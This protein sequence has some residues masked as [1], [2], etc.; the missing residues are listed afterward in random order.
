VRNFRSYVDR[1][2][3]FKFYLNTTLRSPMPRLRGEAMMTGVI[4]VCLRNH[5]VDL[6]I[7]NGVDGF[8]AD[9]PE[10]LA[11][12]IND[13]MRDPARLAAMSASAGRNG[14]CATQSSS[15]GM[16]RPSA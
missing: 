10:D 3:Q 12:F 14:P 9:R 7:D 8:Y 1:I 13:A 2:R 16:A 4:P 11:D 15:S 6:F 5:D